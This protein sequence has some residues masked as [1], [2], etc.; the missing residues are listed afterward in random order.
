MNLT[1]LLSFL[2]KIDRQP[3]K[4]L[5][6][7][8]LI[9]KNI[10]AKIVRSAEIKPGDTVLEIG[11]GPGA[12]TQALLEAGANV[13]AI[14]KDR[15]LSRE[16]ARLQTPDSRL[17]SIC[18]DFLD[19]DLSSLSSGC[20]DTFKVVAN[21]PYSITTPILEKL[22]S[23]HDLFSSLTLMVQKEV[24]HRMMANS[25]CKDFSS[26]S[27]FLQFYTTYHSSFPVGSSCF[28]P[29]PSVDSTVIRFDL[30]SLLPLPNPKPFFSI[31]RRA[32]R[33]RRKMLTTSLKEL[34]ETEKIQKA[35]IQA[36]VRIDAR[37]EA[38]SMP[39]WVLFYKN[40]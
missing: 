30:R 33:Q 9:D 25:G 22:L 32:F 14:E 31:A 3:H 2:K 1:E 8:F 40:M 18:A 27:L 16:L 10:L 17:F 6:Q 26:L 11:P 4:G 29:Q 34:Y 37:P 7:N 20:F 5:S 13:F 38:L 21:L 15:V 28:Y 24:A 19:F 36:G 23:H 35:L 12:L 39:Q